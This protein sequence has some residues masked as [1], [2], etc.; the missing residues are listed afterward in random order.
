MHSPAKTTA[1]SW[2][3]ARS[4][5]LSFSKVQF[6]PLS[7]F[8]SLEELQIRGPD[9]I[10]TSYNTFAEALVA[11]PQLRRLSLKGAALCSVT[12]TVVNRLTNLESLRLN[13]TLDRIFHAHLRN[14]EFEGLPYLT[15]PKLK[16]L[17]IRYISRYLA[18]EHIIPRTIEHLRIQHHRNERLTTQD[19]NYIARNALDV[20]CLEMNIGALANLWHPTAVAGL[21]VVDMDVYRVFDALSSFRNL[22]ILRLFP[23]YWQSTGGYLN[24]SQPVADEQAVRI[25]NHLRLKCTKLDLLI[26][27]NSSQDYS[28][29]NEVFSRGSTSEPM[30]WSVRRIGQKTLLTTHEAKRTYRLEQIWEGERRLTMTT[31]RQYGRR[32]HFDELEDWILSTYE[33]PFDEPQACHSETMHSGLRG[34]A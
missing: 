4:H 16:E 28:T 33:F 25:F 32:Q 27:S 24:F 19:I 22:R 9:T 29:R 15:L 23:S 31:I 7:S 11:I 30:K 21:D 8:T 17:E 3:E 6:P 13:S 2:T 18:I 34:Q 1:L 12:L 14:H 5:D 10:D 20:R 26:I